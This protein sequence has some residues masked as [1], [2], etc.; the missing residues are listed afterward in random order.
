MIIN[1][2]AHNV[3]KPDLV[4]FDWDN[5]LVEAWESIHYAVQATLA[6]YKKPTWSLAETKIKIHRSIR[7]TVP[8]YFPEYPAEEVEKTYRS[9][10]KTMQHKISPLPHAIDTIKFLQD[11]Q[12]YIAII[13]NKQNLLLNQEILS[14]GWQ[15]YFGM[16]IGAGDLEED[17]PSKITVEAVLKQKQVPKEKIWFIGDSITDMETAYN[18]NCLPVLFDNIQYNQSLYSHCEP[19]LHCHDHKT[20]LH[21]L[22]KVYGTN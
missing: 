5:T 11:R 16:I 1:N 21:Y 13:S 7:D 8:K 9:A 20:L 15:E 14:L 22:K 19:K 3:Y 10:Y 4:I 6:Y 17:K 2:T 18:A 12:T